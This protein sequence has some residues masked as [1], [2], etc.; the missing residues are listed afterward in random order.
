[1]EASASRQ[2]VVGAQADCNAIGEQRLDDLHGR[3][4]I[5]RAILR[6]HDGGIADVEVHVARRNHVAVLS[7]HP[8]GG[9]K[10]HH[11]EACI[12]QPPSGILV[13]RLVRVVPGCRRDRDPSG[14]H[15]AREVVDVAVGVVVEEPRPQPHDALEAEIAAQPLLDLAPGHCIAVGVQ[16]ALLGR[17]DGAGAVAIDG[18]AL[19]DPAGFCEGQAAISSQPFAD[20]LVTGQV[21]LAAPAVEA[22]AL[23]LARTPAAEDDRASVAQPDVAERLDDHLGKRDELGC[24]LRG[25]AVGGD[26]PHRFSLTVRVDRLGERGDF[27]LGRLEI[28]EPELGV[29]WETDPDRFVRGPFGERGRGGCCHRGRLTGRP[30]NAKPPKCDA[31]L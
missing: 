12:R 22:E 13:H 4:V 3:P 1:M 25:P 11:I 5:G 15:E 31:D 27:A 28:G 18:S 17:D 14:S 20:V 21:V 26:E 8:A 19:E 2:D 6:D 23:R 29:A 7:E 24:A 30:V 9:R 16:E 10:R